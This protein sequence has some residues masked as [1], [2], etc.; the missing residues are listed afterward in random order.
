MKIL[1]KQM[2]REFEIFYEDVK[3][4]LTPQIE[5]VA[6][7]PS[8]LNPIEGGPVPWGRSSY[9]HTMQWATVSLDVELAKAEFSFVAAH[10][11]G[12]ILYRLRKLDVAS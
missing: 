7:D 4:E 6:A 11:L 8:S 2:T 5:Y 10:E 12:H 9:D 3:A 1:G